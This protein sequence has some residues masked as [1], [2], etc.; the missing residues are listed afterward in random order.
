MVENKTKDSNFL[1]ISKDP[2]LYKIKNDLLEKYLDDL[3]SIYGIG[4]YF[5]ENLPS[6]WM[7]NDIDIIVI[8]KS[9][10][11]TQKLDWTNF[12]YGK[13]IINDHL[14][15][16]GFYTLNLFKNKAEFEDYSWSNY[17]WS[18][19]SLRNLENSKLI[20]GKDIR[21]QLPDHTE[22]EFNYDDIL[23]RSFYY[24]EKSIKNKI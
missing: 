19:I 4:S 1:I 2:L 15:W 12:R 6:D 3:V 17:E 14:L 23:S 9:L 22:F 11:K 16:Q 7:K 5:D 18:L 13:K 10:E 20:Y 24:F 21:D 8:L